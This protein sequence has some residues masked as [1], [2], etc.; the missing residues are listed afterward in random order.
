MIGTPNQGTE[1]P[2]P[3]KG[4]NNPSQLGEVETNLNEKSSPELSKSVQSEPKPLQLGA[5]PLAINDNNQQ[6]G[7]S[8]TQVAQVNL[9][10][11]TSTSQTAKADDVDVIEK[12]WVDKAKKIAEANRDNPREKSKQLANVKAEYIQKRY[13]KEIKVSEEASK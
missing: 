13:G 5:Q 1:L 4:G 11:T 3:L 10:T 12:I 9:T 6:A 8:A 7:T 2:A